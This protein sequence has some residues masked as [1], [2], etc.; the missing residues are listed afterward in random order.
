MNNLLQ[1]AITVLVTSLIAMVWGFLYVKSN[2]TAVFFTGGSAAYQLAGWSMI[3]GFLGFFVGIGLLIG[4]LVQTSRN[5][6]NQ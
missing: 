4:G 2:A 6:D 3:L 1:S 5:K